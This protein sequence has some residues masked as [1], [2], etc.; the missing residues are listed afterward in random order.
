[1]KEYL[2]SARLVKA[3]ANISRFHISLTPAHAMVAQAC[4]GVLLHLDKSISRNNLNRWPL[5]EYS[6]QHWLDHARFEGVMGKIQEGM[7]R[8]FDPQ[9]PHL[10]VWVWIYDPK[11]PSRVPF[12]ISKVPSRLQATPLH[13]AAFCGLRDVVEFLVIEHSQ[14]VNVPGFNL[15]STAL[16]EASSMEVAQLLLEHGADVRVGDEYTETPLHRA[17]EMGRAEV[18]QLLLGHGADVMAQDVHGR[19]PLHVA[20]SAEVVLG[21]CGGRSAPPRARRRCDGPG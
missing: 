10:T 18:V 15:K 1:V 11:Y 7:K 20:S 19:T 4:L 21:R 5:A 14:D 13:Y 3:R 17:S 8:L 12:E 16:H 2:T 9:Q 6:A